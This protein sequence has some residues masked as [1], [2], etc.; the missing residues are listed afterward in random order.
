MMKRKLAQL[1]IVIIINLSYFPASVTAQPQPPNIIIY[2]VD[3]L[4]YGDLSCYGSK[5]INTP[6][7]DKMASEG[8]RLTSFITASSV[9]SPSR[10]GLLTGRYPTRV[11]ITRVLFPTD[12]TGLPESETTIAEALKPN[13]YATAC[14]G[15][16]HLGHL[17]QFLPTNH[18]FDSYF[19]IPYS[20]DMRPT[21]LMK[22]QETIEEPVNQ[23]TLTER[24]TDEAVKFITA[25]RNKPF[26]LYVAHAMPHI[27]LHVSPRFR[28]KSK[29][30]L[31]GD[32]VEAIDWS[33]GQ[34]LNT[35]KQLNLDKNTLVIFASDNGPW[36][37]GSAGRLRGRKATTYEGGVRVPFIA[38]WQNHIPRGV[39]SDEPVS[40]LDLFPT[41]V[42]ATGAHLARPLELDGQDALSFLTGKATKRAARL[43]L[44]FD[45]LNLQAARY[46]Q[47]KIH[48]ARYNIPPYNAA[49][50]QRKNLPLNPP[51]LYDLEIDPDESYDLAIDHPEVIK[52]LKQR[53]AQ[54]MKTF[55][56]A[57]QQ[58][59]A[60]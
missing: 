57:V 42:T 55:P 14:I 35:L 49:T 22:N 29:A 40:A 45:G 56:E 28:G 33:V 26:F 50:S 38:R 16:W 11:G 10:A 4:G 44:Y 25:S 12:N 41:I 48:V 3:D 47:W 9:C 19:G 7:L 43:V 17:P 30:G 58:A 20:N 51:E 21:P 24:Y 54:L 6:N 34:I 1:F 18:G 15:K 46:G 59:Y 13:G 23:D 36:Y 60:Q 32:A 39:V 52:D 2:F 37:Q 31:Y 53:I 27:P 5:A 8:I